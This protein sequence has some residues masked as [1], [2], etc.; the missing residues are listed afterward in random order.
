MYLEHI[1]LHDFRDDADIDREIRNMFFRAN[2]LVR[3]FGKCSADVINIIL[4]KSYC[5]NMYDWLR[6]TTT[7]AELLAVYRL[8]IISALRSYLA[9]ANGLV[10]HRCYLSCVY[11]RLLLYCGMVRLCFAACG[12]RVLIVLY[13]FFIPS[14]TVVFYVSVY[15]CLSLGFVCRLRYVCVCLCVFTSILILVGRSTLIMFIK[16]SLNLLAFSTKYEI[17]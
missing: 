16:K 11:R 4:F 7:L 10:L 12:A 8:A 5:L 17:S 2:M 15:L 1:I 13:S 6:G 14:V 3:E 9:I